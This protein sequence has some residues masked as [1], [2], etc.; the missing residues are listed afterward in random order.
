[1]LTT[2][3]TTCIVCEELREEGIHIFSNFICVECEQKM[4]STETDDIQYQYFIHQLK[5]IS[6]SYSE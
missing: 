5:N 6:L 1:M 2:Q 4:V 3:E